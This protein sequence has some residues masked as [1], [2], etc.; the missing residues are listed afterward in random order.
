MGISMFSSALVMPMEHVRDSA[1]APF[2]IAW[3]DLG[4][5]D[6]EALTKLRESGSLSVHYLSTKANENSLHFDNFTSFQELALLP[7]AGEIGLVE[8][9]R[10]RNITGQKSESNCRLIVHPKSSNGSAGITIELK[11]TKSIKSGETLLLDLPPRGSIHELELLDHELFLTGQ[12]YTTRG[13]QP[14][15]ISKTNEL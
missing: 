14:N 7:I 9:V 11:A 4:A 13:L 3:E 6:H 5:A 10:I 12:I 15:V 8:R 2:V 1:I